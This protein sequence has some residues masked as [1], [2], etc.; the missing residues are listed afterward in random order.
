MQIINDEIKLDAVFRFLSSKCVCFVSIAHWSFQFIL[1]FP[2]PFSNKR[3]L[4]SA[5]MLINLTKYRQ[6]F[7]QNTVFLLFI[8]KQNYT[9]TTLCGNLCTLILLDYWLNDKLLCFNLPSFFFKLIIGFSSD[10]L[11]LRQY[12]LVRKSI[13][14][15]IFVVY[16]SHIFY[17][18]TFKF[19]EKAHTH[20]YDTTQQYNLYASRALICEFF[21]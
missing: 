20:T 19:L 2:S 16:D 12:I 7:N 4:V 3:C 18:H 5:N 21:F 13:S 8:H 9:Q 6:V 14:M 1:E 11:L 10:R 15:I 17:K